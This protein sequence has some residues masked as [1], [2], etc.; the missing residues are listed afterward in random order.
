MDAPHWGG[1]PD[2]TFGKYTALGQD[3]P[4]PTRDPWAYCNQGN[5][6]E[7]APNDACGGNGNWGTTQMEVWYVPAITRKA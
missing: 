2:L 7:G 1:A 4:A 6:Y 5:T 3:N